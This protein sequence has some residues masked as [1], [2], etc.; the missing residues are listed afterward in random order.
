MHK[1]SRKQA[2]DA[3]RRLA[4]GPRPSKNLTPYET[5][6]FSLLPPGTQ[7]MGGREVE[8]RDIDDRAIVLISSTVIEQS[9]EAALMTKFVEL[10]LDDERRLFASDAAPLFTFA[11]KVELAYALGV[12][13]RAARDDLGCIRQIRNTFAHSRLGI[14]FDTPEVQEAC[15]QISLPTRHPKS[16]RTDQPTREMF[17]QIAFEYSMHLVCYDPH[18]EPK[19]WRH[20]VLDLPEVNRV[21]A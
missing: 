15:H 6:G 13:G 2:M 1:Q 16:V 8:P 20:A 21:E 11:A 7:L 9:L 17:I 3:L 10:S 4:G 5:F 19:A 18:E 12:I 14:S